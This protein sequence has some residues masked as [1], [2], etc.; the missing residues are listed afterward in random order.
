MGHTVQE[1]FSAGLAQSTVKSYRSCSNK[2]TKF[3]LDKGITPFPAEEKTVCCFIA[4]LYVEGLAGSSVKSY[5]AAIRFLQIAMGLGEPHMSEWPRLSYVVRGFKKKA[6][7]S[8]ARTR[9]PITPHILQQLKVVWGKRKDTKDTCM[10]WAASCLCFFSFL[11]MGEAVVPSNSSYD[12]EVHLSAGDV[13]VDN[14]ENPS[15]VEV[16]IKASKTD[17]FRKGVTIYL[18]VTG[19]DICLVA[20]ILSY[21]VQSKVMTKGTQRPFFCFSD[22]RPLTRE[23]FVQEL[24]VALSAGGIDAS[25]YAGHSFRIGA[26]TTAAA[27]GL[28]ESLIKMLGRWE[29]TAYMLYIRTPRSTLCSVAQKLIQHTQG[30]EAKQRQ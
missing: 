24:R 3:C 20:A 26:A 30:S 1:L 18:G 2:Y 16:R 12:P 17:V 19:V 14:R 25:A 4:A 8:R 5:L 11:R 29:S 9:L 13:K 28:P 23:R 22:G 27:C 6:S 7:G 10:L 15:F 21:M